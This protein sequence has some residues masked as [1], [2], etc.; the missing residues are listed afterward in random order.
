MAAR[1]LTPGKRADLTL[2]QRP[3]ATVKPSPK[4]T[5]AHSPDQV[6]RLRA[7]LNRFGWTKPIVVD[8]KGEILAGHGIYQAALQDGRETVP[9]VVRSGLS[10]ADKRAYRIADNKLAERSTWDQQML[11]IELAD[12]QAQN[13]DMALTGFDQTEIADMLAPPAQGA[14]EPPPAVPKPNPISRLGDVWQ[15]GDHRLI[16]GDNSKPD[17]M[18]ALMAGRQAQVVHTDPPYGV[19]YQGRGAD[20]KDVIKGDDKRRA[21]LRAMVAAALG[22]AMLHTRQDAAFYIWHDSST[23]DDFTTAMRDVGLVELAM[24]IWV[25]PGGVMGW[26]DYRRAHEPCFYAARQGVEPAF[27]GDRTNTTVWHLQ[28]AVVPGQPTAIGKGVVLV[29]PDGQELYVTAGAPKGKK[30]RH[31][32]VA[33][34]PVLLQGSTATDDVWMVGRD[35]GS[36][37]HP[38]AKPVELARRAIVNSSVEGDIVLDPFSGSASTIMAAHQTGRIGYAAELDPIYVDAGVLRWQTMTGLEAIHAET[39]KTYATTAKA[40]RRGK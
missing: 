19:S 34:D 4:N 38:T 12:L 2:E 24:L 3:I 33:K 9:V 20:A 18:T 16:C 39:G 27:H 31:I 17:V 5:R 40:R 7:S 26:S 22:Q 28:H 21:A 15:M 25:K 1:K 35:D 30:V 13:Y 32:H 14:D 36:D 23:R 37:I 11:G 6:D 8:E 10:A 29:A